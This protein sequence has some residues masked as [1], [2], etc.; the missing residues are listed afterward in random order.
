MALYVGCI[1][2]EGHSVFCSLVY[3]DPTGVIRSVHRKLKPTYEERLVW[4]QG[5]GNGLVV[6]SL[7]PFHV[8]GLNCWENW[9]PLART[10]LYGQ[11]EDLHVAVWP[12][13]VHNTEDITRFMAREG[14][15]YVI[16]ACGLMPVANIPSDLP[17]AEAMTGL[18]RPFLANGGSCIAGPD[19]EW[20]IPPVTDK[21][22]LLVTALDFDRLNQ[23]RLLFDPTGHY[24]RN[25]VFNLSVNRNRTGGVDF[26]N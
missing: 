8:G 4:S 19:G 12:G 7:P 5:D 10:S 17:G 1:E 15:S 26:S 21:E 11:G 20:V 14:R 18:N 13:S 25:D 16:S 24:S 9:M 22:S 2:K 3:I 23:E 6:H